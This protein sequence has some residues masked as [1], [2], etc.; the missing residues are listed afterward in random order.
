L[1]CIDAFISDKY[2]ELLPP[3]A[4]SD[5]MPSSNIKTNS[6]GGLVGD[7]NSDSDSEGNA[8]TLDS[9]MKHF[10]DELKNMEGSTDMEEVSNETEGNIQT[11]GTNWIQ[12]L[13]QNSG[14][15][16][17]WNQNTNKVSWQPPLDYIAAMQ[18]SKNTVPT[19]SDNAAQKS[20]KQ[21][22][23]ALITKKKTKYPWE[24]NSESED[25]KI[26]IINSFGGDSDEEK[27]KMK[28]RKKT[29][30][31][32]V[33]KKLPVGPELPPSA[34][35]VQEAYET[36]S[37]M[38]PLVADEGPPGA[39]LE[40][41]K[42]NVI[43]QFSSPHQNGTAPIS[44]V[45]VKDEPADI[46]ET[47]QIST[48]RYSS[49][50]SVA[51]RIITEIEK[52]IPPDLKSRKSVKTSTK[53]STNSFA[54]IASYGDDSDVEDNS[55]PATVPCLFPAALSGAEMAA[56]PIKPLAATEEN[57]EQIKEEIRNPETRLNPFISGGS[58]GDQDSTCKALKRKRRIEFDRISV[59]VT[60]SPKAANDL[61]AVDPVVES[62][63]RYNMDPSLG[64]HKGF[65]FSE[66]GSSEN[67][68]TNGVE[69]I[70]AQTT[71]IETNPSNRKFFLN[72]N[73]I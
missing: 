36:S 48:E 29:E 5:S 64:E 42:P 43:P 1:Y 51:N 21:G 30:K 27:P 66:E 37:L 4:K 10:M 40:D 26:E 69:L 19:K 62:D 12:C 60:K 16:Y 61:G 17:Y 22:K 7:Y 2:H 18:A 15:P 24:G 59:E 63:V 70:K 33:S 55:E 38:T 56:P 3:E 52:E 53:K 34:D 50:I 67:Q 39:E 65:G 9:E 71:V 35:L 23:K 68:K 72:P 8:S 45:P 6:L 11:A 13:D 20:A 41:I 44:S 28:K 31:P 46:V 57:I 32:K 54:L 47:V 73:M 49:E 58:I 25:E 14:Y